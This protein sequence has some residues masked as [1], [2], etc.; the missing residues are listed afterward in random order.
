[1]AASKAGEALSLA[2]TGLEHAEHGRYA[3][4]V[5]AFH[6]ALQLDG[7][8]PHLYNNL[9]LSLVACCK[10]EEALEAYDR[11]LQLSPDSSSIH[12]N[13]GNLCFSLFQV[14]EAL[15]H[16]KKAISSD[17]GNVSAYI[18]L[19][20][21]YRMC[22]DELGCLKMINQALSM[23]ADNRIGIDN[24]LSSLNYYDLVPAFVAGEH[25]RLAGTSFCFD[26]GQALFRRENDSPLRVGFVSP[27]FK[28]HP[29]GQFFLPVL[30]CL[31]KG[32][33]DIYCYSQVTKPDAI[34][35]RL[36]Q[37]GGVWRST[38]G[39]SDEVMA[40]LI[41][42]DQIDVLVDLAG[43]TEGHRLGVF[44]RKPARIQCA[45]LGYP[46]TTG[47]QQMDCRITD[48]TADPPGMTEH[49]HTETLLR[50]P[51]CFLAYQPL[52]DSLLK[53]L[54]EG[55]ITFCCFN[56]LAK[57]SDSLLLLWSEIMRQVPS[58]RLI[59]KYAFLDDPAVR[60]L[61][62][63]RLLRHHIDISRVVLRGFSGTKEEHLALYGDCHIALDTYP[64]NGTMT[65][66]EAL[67]MGV[68]VI[69]QA[70]H[71]HVARVGASILTAVGCSELVATDAAEYIRK[72]VALAEEFARMKWYRENLRG[73]MLVS[74]LMDA[75]R[76]ASELTSLLVRAARGNTGH[77]LTSL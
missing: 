9:A 50:L 56:N 48:A 25:K 67:W 38:V 73:K 36:R 27:D 26:T 19:S 70:G 68:P 6:A 41:R 32:P 10:P 24:Y 51:D 34:T 59:L 33:V 4:A 35:D 43:L 8:N 62:E 21:A 54:P 39:L 22:G 71:A 57:V 53:P 75:S 72:A 69:S 15:Y 46:N 40:D 16:Y 77:P 64:Y 55:R 37:A 61:T 44:A 14:Q 23:D 12:N 49:L 52:E 66:C 28:N 18:N 65:T 3:E 42:E 45:W 58:A 11:A 47:L 30:Q 76:F 5:Q 31:N 1:M 13:K 60:E 20:R 74:P 63:A 29:V 17:P 2:S 7:N